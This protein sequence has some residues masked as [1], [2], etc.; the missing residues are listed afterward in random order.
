[1]VRKL[2]RQQKEQDRGCGDDEVIAFHHEGL[3]SALEMLSDSVHASCPCGSNVEIV[4]D[5]SICSCIIL[6]LS[7]F[8][9]QR[10]CEEEKIV[11][12]MG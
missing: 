1:M 11:S 8:S 9:T 4:N 2:G 7:M 3:S 10:F 6:A 12:V 5:V